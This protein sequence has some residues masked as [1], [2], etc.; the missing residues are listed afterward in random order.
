M[1]PDGS[2]PSSAEIQQFKPDGDNAIPDNL[3]NEA[4]NPDADNSSYTSLDATP[5]VTASRRN[6]K[7]G[8]IPYITVG[9]VTEEQ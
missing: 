8:S 1:L 4:A 5:S 3:G 7:P 2:T 9:W 6:R